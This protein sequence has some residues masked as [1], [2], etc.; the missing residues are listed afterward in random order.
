MARVEAET[1][2]WVSGLFKEAN[3]VAS[4]QGSGIKEINDALKT[5]SK[6]LTDNTVRRTSSA[7]RKIFL[8]L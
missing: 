4:P 7:F 6:N 3:I 8:L 2:I 5:A 1:D